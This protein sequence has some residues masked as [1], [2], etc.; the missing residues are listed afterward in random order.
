MSCS[1]ILCYTLCVCV[2]VCVRVR[3]CVCACSYVVLEFTC[4]CL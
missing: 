2:R 1:Q 4:A 3:V